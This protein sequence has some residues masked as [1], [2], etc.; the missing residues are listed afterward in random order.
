MARLIQLEECTTR[1]SSTTRLGLADR[2][3]FQQLAKVLETGDVGHY[4]AT[5][6]S[7]T[8]WRNWP[9]GGTL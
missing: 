9:E 1:T 8:H 7:N 3:R 6:P 2:R 4:R 5:K